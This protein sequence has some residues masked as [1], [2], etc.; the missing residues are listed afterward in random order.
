VYDPHVNI[1]TRY[2]TYS[3]LAELFNDS[4]VISIH[5]HL[6]SKTNNLVDSSLLNLTKSNFAL[7]NTSRGS[8]VNEVDIASWIDK[9]R[10]HFYFTDVVSNELDNIS[11]SELIKKS[12]ECSQII[13][14]P[15][16][17][18]MTLRGQSIAYETIANQIIDYS[19][20]I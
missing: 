8:I 10:G 5:V 9:S 18:G 17:G 7:I 3:N 6:D 12:I 19:N 14:T 1:D 16:I 2:L 11:E 4:D 20:T 13:V 15:H